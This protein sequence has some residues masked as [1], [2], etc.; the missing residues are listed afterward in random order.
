MS[1][2]RNDFADPELAVT[3]EQHDRIVEETGRSY[4]DDPPGRRYSGRN[5]AAQHDQGANQ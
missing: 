3:K 4:T 5:R 2:F 1:R